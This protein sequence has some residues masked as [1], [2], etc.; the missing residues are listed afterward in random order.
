MNDVHE[1]KQYLVGLSNKDFEMERVVVSR[2]IKLVEG[3]L[4]AL[5]DRFGVRPGYPQPQTADFLTQ[6]HGWYSKL[7]AL[8]KRAKLCT[9]EHEVRF[10]PMVALSDFKVTDEEREY[11]SGV[12]RKYSDKELG[13]VYMSSLEDVKRGIVELAKLKSEGSGVRVPVSISAS[14]LGYT[15]YQNSN[16]VRALKESLYESGRWMVVLQEEVKRRGLPIT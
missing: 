12:V 6:N 5:R 16:Q 14:Q 4:Q 3:E 2:E 9:V 10:N 11:F 13:C 15:A 1:Y 7:E 8:N